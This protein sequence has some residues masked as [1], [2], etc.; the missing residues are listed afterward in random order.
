MRN[1]SSRLGVPAMLA[2]LLL[3]SVSLTG[4]AASRPKAS[5]KASPSSTAAR[6]DRLTKADTPKP[7]PNADE[8]W[9]EVGRKAR[10]ETPAEEPPD[11]LHNLLSS[12]KAREIERSLGGG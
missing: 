5:V 1:V 10:S 3:C 2:A 9:N 7:A 6:P 11:P 12:P 4:C 8:E